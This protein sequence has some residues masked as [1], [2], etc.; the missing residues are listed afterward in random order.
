MIRPDFCDQPYVAEVLKT[1]ANFS[2]EEVLAPMIA[3]KWA[4]ER[5]DDGTDERVRVFHGFI[6]SVKPY[7]RVTR[8]I[9]ST[10][11]EITEIPRQKT[12]RRVAHFL[13]DILLIQRKRH[14]VVAVPF[15]G[16]AAKSFVDVDKLLAGTRTLYERLDITKM[17]V[18]LGSTGR[19][20][21]KDSEIP[22]GIILT[23]CHLAYNDPVERRRHIDQLRLSGSNLG[24]SSIY[25]GLIAPVLDPTIS[26]LLVTPILLGFA[27]VSGGVKRSGVIT[28]RHGNFKIAV[29]PG[30]RQ[31]IR[32]FHLLDHIEQMEKVALTTSNVPIRQS[33]TIEGVE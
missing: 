28:D 4:V 33:S 23:R 5:V 13:Y 22:S 20:S 24:A 31:I 17:V 10:N 27:L 6:P 30:L 19:L 3:G 25:A 2:V 16:L 14:L 9:T 21:L 11:Q 1:S 7:H 8:R 15:H 18:E 32:V 26:T 12:I 29:G